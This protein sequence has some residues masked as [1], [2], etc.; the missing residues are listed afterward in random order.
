MGNTNN[1]NFCVASGLV[2]SGAGGGGTPGM[3]VAC[4][5]AGQ[6]C[7]D[8]GGC[9]GGCCD[10]S[11]EM[12]VADGGTCGAMQGTCT[13]GGCQSGAC[14]K[15]GEPCCAG[16][17][18]CTVAF[19]VCNDVRVCTACG[20]ADQRC[21]QD[22]QGQGFCAQPYSCDDNDRC[23]ACGGAGQP[24]CAGGICATGTCQDPGVCR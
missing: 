2:C 20:G 22:A 15:I 6:R 24:C 7:C 17:V 19:S 3:C 12:C 13:G 9:A 11:T 1:G 23:R 21:C 16:G 14:G 18:G 4:G 8:G 10:N 5:A